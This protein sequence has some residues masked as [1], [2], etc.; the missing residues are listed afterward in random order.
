M[1]EGV[2]F[3]QEVV[4][5]V[6]SI[7][8]CFEIEEAELSFGL[9][10]GVCKQAEKEDWLKEY[11]PCPLCQVPV[12]KSNEF[13]EVPIRNPCRFRRLQFRQLVLQ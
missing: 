4:E 8:L 1:D 11:Q 2:K 3:G 7:E 13:L 12:Q 10:H 5:L 9:A 6:D